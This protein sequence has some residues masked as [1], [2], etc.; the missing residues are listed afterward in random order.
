MES[1]SKFL[2]DAIR[3]S[4]R[5]DEIGGELI[6]L[7]AAHMSPVESVKVRLAVFEIRAVLA[8]AH[9]DCPLGRLNVIEERLIAAQE[10][11]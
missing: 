10:Q 4:A 9:T 7:A 6:E 1:I 2:V 8:H 11:S 5:I 3:A